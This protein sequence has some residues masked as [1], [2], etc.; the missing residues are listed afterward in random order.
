MYGE[1]DTLNFSEAS[2]EPSKSTKSSKEYISSLLF[3][4]TMALHY[5]RYAA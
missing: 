3:E 4:S 5:M 2:S 1:H